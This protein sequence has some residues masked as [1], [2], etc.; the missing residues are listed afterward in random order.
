MQKVLY[1]HDQTSNGQRSHSDVP[2]VHEQYRLIRD[3][4]ALEMRDHDGFAD[5]PGGA[6]LSLILGLLI[7]AILVVMASCRLRSWKRRPLR[8]MMATE[9]DDSC[10]ESEVIVNGMYL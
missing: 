4:L 6:V 10:D 5:R 9:N 1:K 3:H 2:F 7:T 8:Q